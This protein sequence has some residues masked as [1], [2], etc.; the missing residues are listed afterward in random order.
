MDERAALRQ[1]VIDA[2]DALGF[3]RQFGALVADELRTEYA[4]RR[5]LGYLRQAKPRRADSSTIRPMRPAAPFS[6]IFVIASAA[7]PK[8]SWRKE[9]TPPITHTFG[10]GAKPIRKHKDSSQHATPEREGSFPACFSYAKK[11]A[12]HAK[13]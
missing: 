10:I 5:M 2:I 9:A 6:S 11:Q 12:V 4:L 13:R 3:G 7:L 1:R 8:R